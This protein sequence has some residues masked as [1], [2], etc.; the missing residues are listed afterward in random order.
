MYDLPETATLYASDR[1]GIYIPQ[2]FAE[3][4]NREMLSGVSDNDLEQLAL[5]PDS[6]DYYW[7]IWHDVACNAIVTDS[8]GTTYSLYQDG[9]LWFVPT[10][11]E[12]EQ[13]EA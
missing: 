13:E 5:G 3:S 6:C 12:P 9:D 7:D 4:I 2:Y 11:W 8:K 10:D 1:H